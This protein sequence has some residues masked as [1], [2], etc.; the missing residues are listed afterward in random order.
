M[1]KL[2]YKIPY[3]FRAHYDWLV[4][5]RLTPHLL[6]KPSHPEVRLPEH[7]RREQVL[8]L[9]LAPQAIQH[10]S[11][12]Q[13]AVRFSARFQGVSFAILVP[14]PAA[15]AL[16]ARE[17]PEE[18]ELLFQAFEKND[19]NPENLGED[20]IPMPPKHFSKD[21]MADS[22]KDFSGNRSGDF[23]PDSHSETPEE[24]PPPPK[25]GHLRRIK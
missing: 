9:N 16:Y 4:D 19:N 25:G 5:N 1:K 8:V 21:V 11:A 17:R 15:L 20:G 24:E 13:E 23:Q 12:D 2:L 22:L 14:W 6:L 10:L 7:L 3:I 18:S